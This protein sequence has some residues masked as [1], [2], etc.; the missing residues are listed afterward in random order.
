MDATITIT[1]RSYSTTEKVEYTGLSVLTEM[2]LLIQLR[3]L[4]TLGDQPWAKGSFYLHR[5]I[6]MEKMA[7][8][9]F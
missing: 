4:R 9:S 5:E 7:T 3:Q 1:K 8:K 2:V 6:N